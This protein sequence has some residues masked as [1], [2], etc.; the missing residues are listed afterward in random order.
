MTT[1]IRDRIITAC[2]ELVKQRGFYSL[3]VDEL[4]LKAGISKRTLYKYFRSK[5]EVIEATV[6]RFMEGAAGIFEKMIHGDQA[7]PEVMTAILKYL[8][9]EGQFI[10]GPVGLADLQQYYPHLW[11]RIDQ[12]RKERI[13]VMI[14]A[15]RDRS[16]SPAFQNL[17]HR[18]VAAVILASIQAV[19]NPEF[20]LANNMKFEDAARDVV[21]IFFPLMSEAQPELQK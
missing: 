10:T 16:K 11:N 4:A 3:T 18:V 8:F 13:Q 7:L 1:D 12:F 2:T 20:I 14:N 5:D 9:T 17:D 15:A 21:A 19:L 6:Q